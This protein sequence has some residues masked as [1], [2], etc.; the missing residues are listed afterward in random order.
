LDEAY[1]NS[2]EIVMV[3]QQNEPIFNGHY[4]TSWLN[5]CTV[6]K[7]ISVLISGQSVDIWDECRI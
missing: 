1:G 6:P 5:I 3:L 7:K 4:E 2:D